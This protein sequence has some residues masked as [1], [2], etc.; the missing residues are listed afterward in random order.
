MISWKVINCESCAH[1]WMRYCVRCSRMPDVAL[2]VRAL[3]DN[4]DGWETRPSELYGHKKPEVH[5]WKGT[6]K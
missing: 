3:C 2:P 4:Y 1:C 5:I 6:N